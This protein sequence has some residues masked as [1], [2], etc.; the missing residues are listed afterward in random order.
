MKPREEI[1]YED[2]LDDRNRKYLG[3]FC[4][5]VPEE[6]FH[7]AGFTPVRLLTRPRPISAAD[8][9]LQSNVCFL[10]RSCLEMALSKTG[11]AISAYAFAHTCDTMQCLA[12]IFQINMPHKPVFNLIGPVNR[13]AP[14]AKEFL[15]QELTYLIQQVESSTGK[16]ITEGRLLKSIKLYNKLRLQMVQLHN[17]RQ[18]MP[19]AE[20]YRLLQKGMLLP[21][22][23]ALLLL[24][25]HGSHEEAAAHTLTRKEERPGI[26]L[27]GALLYDL[28]LVELIEES[29]G[30][31]VGDNLCNGT[32]YFALPLV[33]PLPGQGPVEA[34]ADRYLQRLS[35]AAKHPTL[36]DNE[37]HL[38][39]GMAETGAKGAIFVRDLFCEPHNW[40]LVTLQNSLNAVGIP[41]VTLQM[42]HMGL[43]EQI[44]N[45]LQAFIERL[46]EEVEGEKIS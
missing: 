16:I 23:E 19:A 31:V 17:R 3:Y 40:D 1:P 44:I 9:H 12:D 26:Y 7:A 38:I 8:A 4:S 42:D 2:L 11:D 29:G 24:K 30:R 35:C 5:Y 46:R 36:D 43:T 13:E 39:R 34:L 21:K 33:K 32:R 15:V 28:S 14:G 25:S 45:R 6:I 22:E 18:D 37:S 10:A 20:F 41:H 27:Q